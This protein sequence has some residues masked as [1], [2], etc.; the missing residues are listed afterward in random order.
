MLFFARPS[1]CRD[2]ALYLLQWYMLLECDKPVH[3][4]QYQHQMHL[5]RYGLVPTL[6]E[7][8]CG[9]SLSA[10]R[11]PVLIEHGTMWYTC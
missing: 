7:W 10:S 6:L 11:H 4:P 5:V 1:V 8:N 2:D 9:C 3:H